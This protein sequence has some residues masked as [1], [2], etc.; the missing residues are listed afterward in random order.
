MWNTKIIIWIEDM[1]EEEGGGEEMGRWRK[2]ADDDDAHDADG[3][4]KF[5]QDFGICPK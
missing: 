4:N 1:Q 3:T 2:D 5:P